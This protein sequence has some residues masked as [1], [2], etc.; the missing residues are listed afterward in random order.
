VPNHVS[1]EKKPLVKK[2]PWSFSR[3]QKG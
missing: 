2:K 3:R 1:T